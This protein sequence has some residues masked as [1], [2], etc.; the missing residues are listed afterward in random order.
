MKIHKIF[1]GEPQNAIKFS[2]SRVCKSFLVG[3]CPHDILA[4]TVSRLTLK[5]T[6]YMRKSVKFQES[7]LEVSKTFQTLIIN[8]L[9]KHCLYLI[10]FLSNLFNIYSQFAHV[11]DVFFPIFIIPHINQSAFNSYVDLK[12]KWCVC[13]GSWFNIWIAHS[14]SLWFITY[15][16][17][18][19]GRE[20]NVVVSS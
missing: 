8:T 17:E 14:L 6:N 1:S 10:T 19:I 3:C 4:T 7:F 18:Y 20:I 11:Y 16:H 13:T 2:D 5:N 12:W 9:L 15:I